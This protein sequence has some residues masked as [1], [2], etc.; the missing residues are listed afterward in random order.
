M[1]AT[2]I[3]LVQG[4]PEWHD[5]RRHHRNASETPAVLGVSPW[6]TPYQLWQQRT[7]RAEVQV[8]PAMMH[9]TQME[10]AAR[11]AY[12]TLT[13]NVMQPLVLVEGEYSASLDGIT[14]DGGLI[15]EVKCP[16]KGRDSELW[17]L[18]DTG[19]LP[20]HYRWQVQHQMMVAGAAMAHV[21]VFDGVEGILLEERPRRGD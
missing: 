15:L 14:L 19:S 11:E 21:Y 7:G 4:S 3:R 10:P 1:S 2:I 17:K 8:T 12:E 18:A 16:V 9:G 5:H 20:E 6:V 13:G